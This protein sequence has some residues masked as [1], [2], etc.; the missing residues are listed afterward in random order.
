LDNSRAQRKQRLKQ[1]KEKA[2]LTEALYLITDGE[3]PLTFPK[4][5]KMRDV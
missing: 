3:V 5:P 4:T 1:E 2:L